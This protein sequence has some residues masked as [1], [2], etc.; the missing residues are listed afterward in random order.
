MEKKEEDVV[1]EEEQHCGKTGRGCKTDQSIMKSSEL[2]TIKY[3]QILHLKK[4][5]THVHY[6]RLK[7]SKN[8]SNNLYCAER[9][10]FIIIMKYIKV[11]LS[12]KFLLLRMHK[13][14]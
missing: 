3:R 13:L 5:Y 6:L 1:F 8:K 10:D 11:H 4:V 7:N 2:E 9:V 12:L 14:Q